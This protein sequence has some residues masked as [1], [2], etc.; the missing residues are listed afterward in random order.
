MGDTATTRGPV[1]G[2][3]LAAVVT[4]VLGLAIVAQTQFVVLLRVL[5]V[6]G[7]LTAAWLAA[8]AGLG[9]GVRRALTRCGD[10]T[11]SDQAA[12]G[13]GVL[14]LADWCVGWAGQLNF[15]VLTGV[16]AVGWALL[17]WHAWS[18][19]AEIAALFGSDDDDDDDEAAT[20][21]KA[22]SDTAPRPALWPLATGGPITGMLVAA[23]CVAPGF[24]WASEFGG[25]DVLEYHL[26]L[27]KEWIAGGAIQGYHHNA[28]AYLPN[29]VEAAYAHLGVWRGSMLD[30]AIAAQLLHAACAIIAACAIG[31]IIIDV[32]GD[33]HAGLFGGAVYLATPWTLVTGSMAYDEQ[34]M[35]AMGAAAMAIAVRIVPVRFAADADTPPH[36]DHPHHEH[37][38]PAC[39]EPGIHEHTRA[40]VGAATVAGL[41]I[42]MATLAKLGGGV[43]V[44]AAVIVMLAG[45]LRRGWVGWTGRVFGF[46][47]AA[48]AV[49][50]LWLVRNYNATGNPVFPMLTDL[51]G[52]GHWTDEQAARWTAAHSPGVDAPFARLW[53]QGVAHLQFGYVVLP[54]A[55]LASVARIATT[56]TRRRV[57]PLL[58]AGLALIIGIWVALT[59]HQ[60]RFL[61]PMLLP[62][63]ALIGLGLATLPHAARNAAGVVLVAVLTLTS[64]Y[65]YYGT[66]P[67][68]PVIAPLLI[69]NT[70]AFTDTMPDQPPASIDT[71]INALPPDAK[72]YS[73]GYARP[74][75]IRR[76]ITYHTVWDASPLGPTLGTGDIDGAYAWLKRQGYTHVI[77]D[78][79]MIGLWTQPGNYGYDPRVRTDALFALTQRHLRQVYGW[80][81]PQRPA[82]VLYEIQ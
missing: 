56:K 65:L 61:I 26:Q 72:V 69:G 71:A 78:W 74:F 8:A 7:A 1:P 3:I 82:Q 58:L 41:L 21:A 51:F 59:H 40:H 36:P 53:T 64:A 25:Y 79:N 77:I 12:V 67:N 4:F 6:S 80:P 11:L 38:G 48:G 63:A 66:N 24:L 22:G 34:A 73:E 32:T 10:L 37:H 18:A 33:R 81:D 57:A 54:A 42:G 27:P 29:M 31:R 62:A 14:M 28:Y 52:T 76:P 45:N 68:Q 39:S 35:M 17:V 5:L 16:S 70:A 75:Y 19:R 44:G 13:V 60:S 2:A 43:M 30:A 46:G 23:A 15:G 20:D 47:V 55:I 49:V 9:Y 50:T